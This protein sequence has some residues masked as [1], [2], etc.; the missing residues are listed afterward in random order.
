MIPNHT[1]FTAAI[2]DKKKVCVRFYSKPDSGVLDRVCAPMEYGPGENLDGLN[3]YWLWDYAGEPGSKTI[4]LMPQQILDLQVLGEAF[5]PS[6]FV[7]APATMPALPA[8]DSISTPAVPAS[9]ARTP[10]L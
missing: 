2:Q 7:S 4:G 5:N 9:E 6:E 1:Q 8:A 10:I 3:R